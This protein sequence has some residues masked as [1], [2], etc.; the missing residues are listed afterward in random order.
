MKDWLDA[1]GFP[2]S[3]FSAPD[4]IWDHS[5]VNIIKKY[6]PYYSVSTQWTEGCLSL[7]IYTLYNG[8]V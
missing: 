4:N 5:K 8:L 7:L 1:N 3:G 2:N 6:H